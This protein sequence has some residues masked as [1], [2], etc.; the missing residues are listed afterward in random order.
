MDF[1]D[2]VEI[3]RRF[4]RI[5]VLVGVVIVV[6]GALAAFLPQKTY[7][8][9]A[10]VIM[11][12]SEESE[13]SIQE[14]NFL[15]PAIQESAQS[16]SLRDDAEE[17]VSSDFRNP[18]PQISATIDASVLRVAA[19]ANTPA[20][21]Q[22][23]ADAVAEEL[24]QQRSGGSLDLTLLDPAPL[25]R[26]PIAPKAVPIMLAAVVVAL[27]S[28]VF[29]A[30]LASR[31]ATTTSP[32]ESRR[33]SV[34]YLGE[35]TGRARSGG[36][37]G[38][39]DAARLANADEVDEPERVDE[40]DEAVDVTTPFDRELMGADDDIGL[41]GDV[42]VDEAGVD[43]AFE[44]RR[45]DWSDLDDD[46]APDDTARSR[47]ADGFADHSDLAFDDDEFFDSSDDEGAAAATSRAATR[48]RS[49]RRTS[50]RP[51]VRLAAPMFVVGGL[52]AAGLLVGRSR[53]ASADWPPELAAAAADVEQ[54]GAG[55]F[56][57]TVA[58][59]VQPDVDYVRSVLGLDLGQ[60]LPRWRALGL[61]SGDDES[62]ENASLAAIVRYLPVWYDVRTQTIRQAEGAAAG[63]LE[64]EYR[65]ALDAALRDQRG[66]VV[67]DA[68]ASE[69]GLLGFT[70]AETLVSRGVALVDSGDQALMS[71]TAGVPEPVAY[72]LRASE[73]FGDAVTARRDGG[74]SIAGAT[75]AAVDALADTASEA[76]PG[77]RGAGDDAVGPA[78]ALG[79]DDWSLVWAAHLP[80]ESVDDLAGRVRR[81]LYQP[82]DRGGRSCVQGVFETEPDEA[83]DTE[84]LLLLDA[85]ADA[86][87]PSADA[88]AFVL[89]PGWFQIVACDPGEAAVAA[90]QVSPLELVIDRQLARL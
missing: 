28:A 11:E 70:S 75:S 1:R 5:A 57:R 86:A 22:E 31:I 27:V 47:R 56:N 55:R 50:R 77:L 87:P 59:V 54:Q 60:S 81:D 82:F 49:A 29:A 10:T 24:I 18:T 71:V 8:T 80:E 83:A 17:R 19:T 61:A 84:M 67:S 79:V 40:F 65:L 72:Q 26:Q 2:L 78:G 13:I 6:F 73:R 88:E 52:V 36:A 41:R 20:A 43:D 3:L 25:R 46:S 62:I 74:E 7:R 23:W 66:D 37:G 16:R 12:L 89:G 34:P 58:L 42:D 14:I 51:A 45:D 64:K 68:A 38:E 21:A 90:P 9:S 69:S 85:W 33:R 35:R 44:A 39:T 30:L 32:R 76:E 15:L 63:G 4:W 53:D 48:R